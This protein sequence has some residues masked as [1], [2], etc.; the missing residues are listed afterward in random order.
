MA[1]SV[2]ILQLDTNFPR[3]PGDVACPHTYCGEVQIIR[4][5]R[6]SV[7]AIVT[8]HPDQ[9]DISP[10][11]AALAAARG[12]V[13]V[14]SCGFLSFWQ[15]HLAAQTDRPFVSSALTALDGLSR[16]YA[17]GE[18]LILT[19]DAAS[20]TPAHLGA[21]GAYATGIIGLP[22]NMHLKQVIAKDLTALDTEIASQEL[23]EL[24][25]QV[26][27]PQHKHLLLECTN[28]PP[29]KSA[30]SAVTGLPVTDILTQIE[31]ARPG[32]IKPEFLS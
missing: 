7:G 17:P 30:L 27:E 4:I 21:H 15:D 32:T 6:A 14:T 22:D 3:V 8:N 26:I 13:V 23:A 16:Q 12:E 20:L 19:F 10:F 29:Y 9:I 25:P 1:P 24:M 11:E 18:V 31:I 28:L 5:P 2:T